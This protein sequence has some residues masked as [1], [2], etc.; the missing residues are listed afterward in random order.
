MYNPLHIGASD[1]YRTDIQAPK[2]SF[3]MPWRQQAHEYHHSVSGAAGSLSGMR[4]P[5]SLTPIG[6]PDSSYQAY[7]MGRSLKKKQKPFVDSICFAKF[8]AAFSWVAVMFLVFIGILIDSQPLF[9]K[10]VLPKNVQF[11]TDD[12]K[13]QVFYSLADERLEPAS[14]AYQAAFIYLLTGCVSLA[15][16]YNWVYWIKMRFWAQYL[17]IPDADSTIPTFH[18][19]D[20]VDPT[21]APSTPSMRAYQ[22]SNR[23]S[24][25]I[26]EKVTLATNRIKGNLAA[27]WPKYQARRRARRRYVG[28]KEI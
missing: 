1:N 13:A 6:I 18:F 5:A 9:I 28:A 23:L 27:W 26:G 12:G 10:G 14:H 20:G 24:T 16:A 3:P 22:Y 7:L 21:T 15:Y 11:N 8:C 2:G 17:D 19:T 4:E 25:S